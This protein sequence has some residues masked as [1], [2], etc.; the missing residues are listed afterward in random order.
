MPEN[1]HLAPNQID[2]HTALEDKLPYWFIKRADKPSVIIYPNRKCSKV[3]N[4][5]NK[6]EYEPFW[7]FIPPISMFSTIAL[8]NVFIRRQR[9]GQR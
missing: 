7:I 2:L 9:A 4:T 1:E 6:Y 3:N 5:L 8:H